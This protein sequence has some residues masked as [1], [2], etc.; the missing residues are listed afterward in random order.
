MGIEHLGRGNIFPPV[1]DA[2]LV[3]SAVFGDVLSASEQ[4]ITSAISA[5]KLLGAKY[6]FAVPR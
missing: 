4:Q 6:V 1:Q 5:A 2:G 3:V